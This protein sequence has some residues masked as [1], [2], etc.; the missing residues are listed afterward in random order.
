MPQASRRILYRSPRNEYRKKWERKEKDIDESMSMFNANVKYS[1]SGIAVAVDA[2]S[3][4]TFER[5]SVL[6]WGK[7][8]MEIHSRAGTY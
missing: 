4:A 3:K 6:R 5:S 1:A 7:A 2:L 8:D